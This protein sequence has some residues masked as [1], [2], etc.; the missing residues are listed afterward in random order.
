M[1]PRMEI[2]RC[3]GTEYGAADLVEAIS[4]ELKKSAI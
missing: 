2:V 4:K 3:F 1:N